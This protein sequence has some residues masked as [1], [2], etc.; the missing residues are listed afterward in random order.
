[1]NL[2]SENPNA[3]L[4]AVSTSIGTIITYLASLTTWNV[5]PAVAVAAAGLFTSFLLLLGR[6]GLKGFCKLLWLGQRQAP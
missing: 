4:A 3:T 1:M 6:T 5:P 2:T